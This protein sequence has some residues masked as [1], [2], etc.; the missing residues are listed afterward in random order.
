MRY[1]PRLGHEVPF[2]YCRLPGAEVPC[3][4]LEGCWVGELDVA[5]FLASHFSAEQIE[6]MAAPPP[7]RACT[8]V[9]MIERARQAGR[10]KP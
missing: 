9:E 4:M 6:R 3:R 10:A 5:A 8:L 1:C 2:R 7:D